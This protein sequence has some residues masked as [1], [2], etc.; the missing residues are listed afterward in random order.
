MLCQQ[1]GDKIELQD[2]SLHTGGGGSN[3]SVGF[4]RMGFS[5]AVL[6]ET[7]KDSW[8]ELLLEDF[9]REYVSTNLLIR[10]KK[11]RTGGS[12]ILVSNEG[13]RTIMTHR[14][15]SSQLD[16]HDIPSSN[17]QRVLWVHL[18]SIS[19]RKNTLERIFSA[20]RE[21]E[22]RLSWN[23]GKKELEL[24]ATEALNIDDCPCEVLLIN[25]R[26]WEMLEPM[27]DVIKEKIPYL[28]VTAGKKGGWVIARGERFEFGGDAAV[29]VVDETGAGDAFAVGFVSG[30]LRG[31]SPQISAEWGVKNAQSVI[32]QTGA[33]PGL[34]RK[35][36]FD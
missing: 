36:A 25:E 3:T 6:T 4:A 21:G 11:E 33:K 1:Y 14:G 27:A 2:F 8:A 31:K 28:V 5:A 32:Q 24:L 34:L 22:S 13:G 17:L 12:V 15:A 30:V 19:G 7:G 20:V 16:P 29:K 23:P 10:E 9:H 35:E 26:E 18:S